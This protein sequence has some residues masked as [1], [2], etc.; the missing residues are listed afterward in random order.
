MSETIIND[1]STPPA[2]PAPPEPEEPIL[3]F[4]V[5]KHLREELQAV[6]A[7]FANLAYIIMSELP[8]NEE[9]AVALRKLLE[10]K[11]AA[12]RARIAR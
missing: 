4:F 6:S 11:D 1:E 8:A 3:Q 10:S 5:F 7:P 2:P 9:R 12:V